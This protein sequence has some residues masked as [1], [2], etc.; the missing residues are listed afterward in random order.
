[1]GFRLGGSRANS[2]SPATNAGRPGP[3]PR[4]HSGKSRLSRRR[5]SS[6]LKCGQ[7]DFAGRPRRNRLQAFV[8]PLFRRRPRRRSRL[9]AALLVWRAKKGYL[10]GRAARQFRWAAR[11]LPDDPGFA[12]CHGPAVCSQR[13]IGDSPP[14][15]DGIPQRSGFEAADFCHR[16]FHSRL[17]NSRLSVA[18]LRKDMGRRHKGWYPAAVNRGERLT[19]WPAPA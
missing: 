19:S 7:E 3:R 9:R 17:F 4:S 6:R 10:S 12:L 5:P 16:S 15:D 13:Q 8:C 14:R 1:M 11:P 18:E 2:L